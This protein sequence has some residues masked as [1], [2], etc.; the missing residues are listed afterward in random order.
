[1][2]LPPGL[3][4]TFLSTGLLLIVVAIPLVRGKVPMNRWYGIRIRR[5]FESEQNWYEIHRYGGQ[6]L[7]AVGVV[8][9]LLAVVLWPSGHLPASWIVWLV[10]AGPVVLAIPF[11]A[12]VLRFAR[13]L[14]ES[15]KDQRRA[16]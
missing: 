6:L 5:A 8:V 10:L 15:G 2:I 13:R 1:M 12:L 16:G 3:A 14:P 9:A 11:L 4:V 7:V